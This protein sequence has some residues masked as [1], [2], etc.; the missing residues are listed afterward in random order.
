M[1][2]SSMYTSVPSVAQFC[3]AHSTPGFFLPWNPN[4][5]GE[6][7][8]LKTISETEFI[9]FFN[10]FSLKSSYQGEGEGED[11]LFPLATSFLFFCF[12]QL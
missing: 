6:K 9:Y 1:V 10:I 5:Q 4:S 11:I 7:K 2:H 3:P 12:S 8:R